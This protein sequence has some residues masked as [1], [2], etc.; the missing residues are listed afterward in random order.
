MSY[1]DWWGGPAEIYATLPSIQNQRVKLSI[2]T[3]FTPTYVKGSVTRVADPA[4]AYASRI[5]GRQILLENPARTSRAK[6]EREQKDAKRVS[7]K[8]RGKARII[9]KHEARRRG[10]WKLKPEEI[11]FNLFLPLHFLWMG[12]MSELLALSSAPPNSHN[13]PAAQVMPSAAGMHA[14]LI[15]A[16]FHG[17]IMTVR[18][19]NNPCLVGLSGIVIHETEN[20]FKVITKQDQLKLIPKK[21]SIFCFAVPLYSFTPSALPPATSTSK[22]LLT[23]HET[24]DSMSSSSPSGTQTIL[25]QPHIEFELYGNHFS[26]RA[27]ER[28]GRKFK[29]KETIEL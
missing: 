26:F 5:A 27:A 8:A 3:P 22:M 28:A 2:S 20:A 7:E 29:H 10:L 9:A 23:S 25:D 24:G 16:D 21:N 19:S 1:S 18:K 14:K 4:Q 15:K 13:D 12:Y 17:S 6:K 11:K